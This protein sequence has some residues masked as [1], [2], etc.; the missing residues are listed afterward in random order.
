MC[1]LVSHSLEKFTIVHNIIW[2]RHKR[3]RPSRPRR[4]FGEMVTEEGAQRLARRTATNPEKVS[5]IQRWTEPGW[6]L[7]S[8]YRTILQA[9]NAQ[10]YGS[11]GH[12]ACHDG[13]G[14]GL[15]T[16]CK[17]GELRADDAPA[18]RKWWQSS[19]CGMR[20]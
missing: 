20:F 7:L 14:G 2:F 12:G 15:S 16:G 17:C 1:S 19:A 18:A 11:P 9:S 8:V 4:S 13:A 6:P 3:S 5:R 10:N